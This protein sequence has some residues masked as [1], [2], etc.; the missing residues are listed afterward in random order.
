MSERFTLKDDGIHDNESDRVF[1]LDKK[2]TN[3]L[4]TM[5]SMI[6]NL[7]VKSYAQDKEIQKL[8]QQLQEAEQ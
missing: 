6:K 4:N 8:L 3:Q 2:L 1:Q 5:D 7:Y